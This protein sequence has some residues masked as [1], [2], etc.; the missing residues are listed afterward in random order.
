MNLVGTS[1]RLAWRSS[2]AVLAASCALVPAVAQAS[3]AGSESKL[4][5]RLAELAKPA[6]RSAPRGEQADRLEL[7]P[8][9]PGSLLR[10]GN[11]VL[12]E[13]RFDGAAAGLVALRAAGAEIVYVSRRYETVTVAV[14]PVD[15]PA[16][17]RI[18]GVGGVTEVLTPI[19]RG[20]DCGG[21]VRSEGDA[22]LGA[23]NAR[24]NWGVDGTGVTVGILS[25]SFDRDPTAVTHAAGDVASGDLPG[26]GS[27]CGSTVPVGVLDDPEAAGADEGRGMAQ[28]VHDLAP[29]AA[30]D[31]ATAFS[32]EFAFA[33][34]IRQLA[35]AGSAVIADDVGYFEE[36]FFQDG[37][38]AVAINEVT[39]AGVSYFS[40]AGNDNVIS[41]GH[42]VG[43]YEAPFRNAG[44]C[45]IGVP[46][47]EGT[48]CTDF[49]PGP[50]VDNTYNMTVAPGAEVLLDLQWAE[51]WEGVGTDLDAYLLDGSGKVLAGAENRNVALTQRPFE[52]LYWE[53]EESSPVQ[54]RL[55]IPRFSGTASPVL[56]FIQLGNGSAGVVPTVAQYE[57]SSAGDVLGP[58]IFGHSGAGSAISVAAVP[59]STYS[60]PESYSSRGP[61]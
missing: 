26:T 33:A 30:I 1:C 31:F 49:D 8:S 61:V 17:G 13:V 58:T 47:L 34:S 56:K 57:T 27:P 24:S 22:Q 18:S 44:S 20:A 46:L 59:F 11:R 50:G 38:I 25:D 55:A 29:G 21:S 3:S 53:N 4:T 15:L 35:A 12:V 45:P 60:S 19:V 54:V 32:G 52:L 43:S 16:I 14:K 41:G 10:D 37:P 6:V 28:I 2:L 42:E 40:A 39:A 51:P 48:E 7:S 36:P 9:G 5:P 23:A